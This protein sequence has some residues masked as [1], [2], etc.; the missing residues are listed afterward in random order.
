MNQN[1]IGMVF[2]VCFA[3]AA[4]AKTTPKYL[5]IPG[6]RDCLGVETIGSARFLCLPSEKPAACEEDSWRQL[7]ELS[8]SEKI[9]AC[10]ER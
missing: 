4:L 8:D 3:L 9:A 7:N 5:G 6:F 1:K 2:I 10:R